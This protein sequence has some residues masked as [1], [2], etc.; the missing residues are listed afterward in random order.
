MLHALFFRLSKPV[1]DSFDELFVKHCPWLEAL[2]LSEELLL[3]KK[4]A[5]GVLVIRAATFLFLVF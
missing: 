3:V 4:L 1:H 2:E 5:Q